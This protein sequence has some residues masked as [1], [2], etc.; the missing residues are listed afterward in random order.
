MTQS[1][2]K[3]YYKWLEDLGK[4]VAGIR[5]S[6]EYTNEAGV[7]KT[8]TQSRMADKTGFDIKYYQDIE[9]GRRPITT[10]TLHQLCNGLGIKVHVLLEKVD[11]Y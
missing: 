3:S 1:E 11:K 9:Y 7:T 4:V 10:R 6:K 5:K 8:M 2:N